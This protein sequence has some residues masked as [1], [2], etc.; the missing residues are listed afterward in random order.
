MIIIK[1]KINREFNEQY[2]EKFFHFFCEIL[3]GYED[4]LNLDF[5]NLKMIQLLL[6]I[7]FF[8]VINLLKILIIIKVIIIFMKNL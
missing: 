5:L 4:Y 7:L 6:L 8:I 1:K 2:Q 3:K